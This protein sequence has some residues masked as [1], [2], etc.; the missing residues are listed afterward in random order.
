VI[1]PLAWTCAVAGLGVGALLVLV[2]GVP[3]CAV[4]FAGIATFAYLTDYAILPAEGVVLIGGLAAFGSLGQV[5]GPAL[6]SQSLSRS[7]GVATGALIGA[8][9]G[10]FIPIPGMMFGLA[11]VGGALG[12]LSWRR[13]S[14]APAIGSVAGSFNGCLLA[15]AFDA[16]AVCG[17]GAVLG[18]AQYAV[19][20]G[21]GGA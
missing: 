4:A 12:G 5:L 2:P 15:A 17:C 19:R 16:V 8:V 6:A 11:I 13:A 20:L 14:L 21:S 3:G 18:S 7:P 10:I 1:E 9:F